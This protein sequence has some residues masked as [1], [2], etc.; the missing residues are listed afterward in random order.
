MTRRVLLCGNGGSAAD[1]EHIAGE[2]VKACALE[3][4]LSKRER[5]E[6]AQVG[7]DGYLAEHLQSG[8]DVL[9]LVSQAALLTAIV[10][11]QRGDV[12]FAQQV[13]AYGRPGDVLWALTTSGSSANVVLALRTAR[14]RGLGTVALSG[15]SGGAR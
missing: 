4:P 1:C 9:P 5:D 3:R 14:A 15:P 10:N 8:L 2:L 11:D 6:L 12:I 13:V 7:D